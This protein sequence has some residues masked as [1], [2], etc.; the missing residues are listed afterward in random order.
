MICGEELTEALIKRA[1]ELISM[2]KI[3]IS[4]KKDN[5]MC[6]QCSCVKKEAS[7]YVIGNGVYFLECKDNIY[8][9]VS[10]ISRFSIGSSYPLDYCV[11]AYSNNNSYYVEKFRDKAEAVQF[12]KDLINELA[13][14]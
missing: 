12:I 4:Y 2:T 7:N 5:D 3:T 14:C 8:I 9:K 1:E 13:S 11:Y 10:E 6:I